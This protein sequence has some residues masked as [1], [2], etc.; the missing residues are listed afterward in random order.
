MS[1]FPPSLVLLSLLGL[2]LVRQETSEDRRRTPLVEVV[3]RVKPAVVS[4]TTN[5]NVVRRTWPFGQE[6]NVDTPGPSGTGVV[7][8]EDGFIITNFH[9]INGATEIQVRFDE[10]DDERVYAAVVVSRKPEEDLALLKIEGEEPFHTVTLCDSDPILGETVI[11]IGNAFGHSHTVSSGIVSGLHRDISTREGLRFANLLQTDASINPGNSGGP[12]LNINGELIGLNSAMQEVAENIGFAIPVNHVRK[13]LS[14]Q[15]LALS[16]ASAWLGFDVDEKTLEV[17]KVVPEGPAARAGLEVGDRLTALAGHLLTSLDG[18]PHD[19]YRRLRISI[20]P[21]KG[22]ALGARR[23]KGEKNFTLLA[24]NK[25]DGILFERLGLGLESVRIGPRGGE[26]FLRVTT[27]QEQGPG[28]HA[29]LKTGDILY[30]V[31]R[32]GP[33]RR[34]TWFQRPDDLAGVVMRLPA[35][36]ELQIEVVRDVDGDG[37]FFERDVASDYNETFSGPFIVR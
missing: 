5:T 7:I 14:E 28:W 23:G 34:A 12:L 16:E 36:T 4:I 19:V 25:V 8:F 10:T 13:V 37:R 18:D 32:P 33:G 9:V 1:V 22:V 27:V 24:W 17:K 30:T 3:E 2:P 11:A 21:G 26:A 6:V 15:L 29:G 35:D 20:Q 31:Q